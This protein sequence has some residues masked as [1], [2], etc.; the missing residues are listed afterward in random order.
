M[1]V[2]V[3]VCEPVKNKALFSP[4]RS[5]VVFCYF[6]KRISESGK[7][8]KKEE[9][10][11]DSVEKTQTVIVSVALLQKERKISL[12]VM[13]SPLPLVSSMQPLTNTHTHT[14]CNNM[15]VIPVVMDAGLSTRSS[16]LKQHTT[17]KCTREM[18]H[19]HVLI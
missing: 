15:P 14:H 16:T 9:R 19:R 3:C 6:N 11:R 2:C 17:V 7:K 13:S 1:Y 10:E 12:M 4:R 8:R 18:A 5:S